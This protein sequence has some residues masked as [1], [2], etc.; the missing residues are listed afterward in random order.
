MKT[1]SLNVD[2][3]VGQASSLS[4]E[5]VSVRSSA[6][7]HLPFWIK[8]YIL[9]AGGILLGGALIRLVIAAGSAQA[10]ALPDPMLGLP[11]RHAILAAGLM[12]LVVACLCLFGRNTLLQTVWLV[13]LATTFVVYQIGLVWMHCHPQATCLGSLTDPLRW[14]RGL[15]GDFLDLVPYYLVFGSYAALVTPC[16]RKR[17]VGQA[18]SL[19]KVATVSGLS[20]GEQFP[21][22]VRFLKISCAECGG[23]IEFSTNLFGEQMP[24]PHCRAI[25]TL[26][27]AVNLK[28][29]CPACE[30]H[31]GF[32][33]YA[34][35]QHI[36]C[37]HCQKEIIL[38]KS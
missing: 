10:L 13:W 14:S 29:A 26:Q 16:L 11:L 3:N 30:G 2:C 9:S 31:V 33:D 24:C 22:H 19:S 36:P 7:E 34:L 6:A 12:E 38:S 37:P 20:P 32:P 4:D 23:H 25:I 18:S 27:K 5:R 35:G 8:L 28:M 21:A 15:P 1:N 17:K